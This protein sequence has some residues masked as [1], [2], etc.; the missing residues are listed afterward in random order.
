MIYLIFVIPFLFTSIVDVIQNK[1]NNIHDMKDIENIKKDYV[2]TLMTIKDL[3]IK[4]KVEKFTGL[5]IEKINIFVEGVKVI[6]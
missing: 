1:R 4:Y 3:S 6:D 2:T 5:E